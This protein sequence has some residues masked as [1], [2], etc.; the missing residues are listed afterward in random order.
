MPTPTI[1][2]VMLTFMRLHDAT[3][4]RTRGWIG[5]RIPG[6]PSSL[7]LHHVGARTGTPRTTTLSYANDGNDYLVVASNGGSDRNPGWLHNLKADPNVEINVGPRRFA[8]RAA[9]VG[10]DDPDHPRLW[11]LVNAN[12]SDRYR[13]YQD[14]TSRPI[15][16]VRLSPA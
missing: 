15:P 16:V 9:V 13:D 11:D 6:M 8:V 10:P 1:P 4:Q 7:M 14:K 5:H 3:Y 12:N 2:P